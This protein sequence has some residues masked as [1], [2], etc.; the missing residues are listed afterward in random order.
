M[1]ILTCASGVL[2]AC[3]AGKPTKLM[4]VDAI[5]ECRGKGDEDVVVVDAIGIPEPQKNVDVVPIYR[6][7]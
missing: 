6:L 2:K 3:K 1:M 4:A 5:A 7:A